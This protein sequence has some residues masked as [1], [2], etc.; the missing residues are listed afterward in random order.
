MGIDFYTSPASAPGRMNLLLAKHLDVTMD[1]KHVDLMKQEQMKPEFIADP[2]KRALVDMR[3]L[4]DISTLY[5]KFGEYVYPTMFQKAP[6]DPE[7]LKKV[8][9]VFGYVELFLK[10]GFIAGSNLTI[11]DFSMA[12]ILSTIEATGILDFS[13]FGKIAEYLEKCRGLMKG[14]DE[15]NQAGA[16]VFGQ[17]YKA[18]LADLKS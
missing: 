6:L 15:L 18:A 11:A 3:L 7:K 8:E 2:Q 16:D 12:S 9:E 10:D 4:F 5:P 13:K 1:V 17:W 14:W